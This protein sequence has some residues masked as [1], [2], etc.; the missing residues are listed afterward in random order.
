MHILLLQAKLLLL[1]QTTMHMIKISLQ[2]QCTIFSCFSKINNILVEKAKDLDVVM[3]MYNLLDY[4]KNY[5]K[6]TENLWN[7]YRDERN[8]G[9]NNNNRDETYYSIKDSE[10][11]NYKSSITGKLENNEDELE[12]TKIFVPL[13]YLSNF[14]RTLDI[15]SINCEVSLDLR[16]SKNCVLTSKA[17]T[18]AHAAGWD[19]PAVAQ[20]NN[21]KNAVFDITDCKLYVPLLL[22]S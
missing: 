4:S 15:P 18:N 7:Y 11:F 2:K 12:N 14:F 8:S 1:I 22:Y 10:S 17:T 3:L 21:L 13:K 9:Y 6:R 16:W 20:I 19:N 5:R